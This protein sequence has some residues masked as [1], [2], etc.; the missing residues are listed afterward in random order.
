ML[1][2]PGSLAGKTA[3]ISGSS[4]GIGA[5][6]AIE[7]SARGASIVLNYP[8]AGE[9]T[10]CVEVG[11]RC[12]SPWIAVCADLSTKEGPEALIRA[13]VGRFGVIDI[14]VNNAAIV[15]HFPTWDLAVETWDET[16]RLN[17]RGTFLL[18]KAALP[19]LTPYDPTTKSRL[20]GNK[21][22]ARI[23]CIGSGSSRLPQ[24]ELLAYSA[25]KGALDPMVK[26]WAKELP[27]KYGCTVNCVAPGPVNTETF[28]KGAAEHL[29][30]ILAGFSRETPCEGAV[31]D[32]GDIAWTVAWLAEEN[33][34][35]INGQCI[36]VNGG[37]S[38]L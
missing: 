6:I 35:W 31:A 26:V 18:T 9:D 22:G 16:F 29:D 13:A 7:L 11:Q 23:I 33:S 1:T 3:V 8:H 21:K 37:L 14:L 25:S 10:A 30:T 17:A 28:R 36:A 15:P 24:P 12:K 19:H 34:R 32:P 4:A 2:T 27:P 5:S 20:S 38:M